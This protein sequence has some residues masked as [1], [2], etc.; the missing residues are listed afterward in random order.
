MSF[1]TNVTDSEIEAAFRN[2][3]FGIINH[4]DY[5]AISILKV[6]IGFHCGHTITTIMNEL[7]LRKKNGGLTKKGMR[8]AQH[9]FAG[10]PI[11]RGGG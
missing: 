5:L 4:R 10:N 6:A 9:A 2:T 8:F 3:H 11:L 1:E 7:G